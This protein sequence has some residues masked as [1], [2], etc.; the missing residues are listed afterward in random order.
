MPT[1]KTRRGPAR[2]GSKLPSAPAEDEAPAPVAA[3]RGRGRPRKTQPSGDQEESTAPSAKNPKKALPTTT[4]VTRAQAQAQSDISVAGAVVVAPSETP[5]SQPSPIHPSKTS[6]DTEKAP[7]AGRK[8]GRPRKTPVADVEEAD[9]ADEV[10]GNASDDAENDDKDDVDDVDAE[11][12]VVVAPR[13]RGR[14][15]KVKPAVSKAQAV[16]KPTTGKRGPGR[17]PKKST[18]SALVVDVPVK[19]GPGRPRKTPVSEADDV[20]DEVAEDVDDANDINEDVGDDDVSE[21]VADDL[22]DAST[23][24]DQDVPSPAPGKRVL[25]GRAAKAQPSAQT[26]GGNPKTKTTTKR[27]PSPTPATAAPPAKRGRGRPPKPKPVPVI[28]KTFNLQ[29]ALGSYRVTCDAIAATLNKPGASFDIDICTVLPFQTSS[30]LTAS[31]DFV[32]FTGTIR[33][34]V[35]EDVLAAYLDSQADG[36]IASVVSDI[37]DVEP[38]ATVLAS[39]P[40]LHLALRGRWAGSGKVFESLTGGSLTFRDNTCAAFEGVVTI[41]GGVG[42]VEFEGVKVGGSGGNPGEWEGYEVE[43]EEEGG[44]GGEVMGEDGEEEEVTVV[45][46]E[47]GSGGEIEG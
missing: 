20:D 28:P 2:K 32:S 44:G 19:R 8:R 45:K 38:A 7:V 18:S 12:S 41:P 13:K 47:G 42:E 35:D 25:R 11:Q 10:D 34:A 27:S 26:K 24:D 17:S 9:E 21:T 4:R 39:P 36:S 1:M 23:I 5:V 6:A 43:E 46:E 37:V 29:F 30:I 31:F 14:P 22:G 15:P 3:P 33:C 40:L 16:A